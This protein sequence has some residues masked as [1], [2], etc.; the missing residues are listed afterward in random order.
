MLWLI[1]RF[2]ESF[3]RSIFTMNLGCR[4]PSGTSRSTTQR[5]TRR[6]HASAWRHQAWSWG[7]H[8]LQCSCGEGCYVRLV[9]SLCLLFGYR[10][11]IRSYIDL[12]S[13]VS[14]SSACAPYFHHSWRGLLFHRQIGHW[15]S[16]VAHEHALVVLLSSCWELE[17]S[18]SFWVIWRLLRLAEQ[19]CRSLYASA[20][21]WHSRI[22]LWHVFSRVISTQYGQTWFTNVQ[23]CNLLHGTC[24]SRWPITS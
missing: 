18:L 19:W 16:A 15:A 10:S 23:R 24:H 1:S 2:S 11:W 21:D 22:R 6:W 9:D 12:P 14:G 7:L 20:L 5:P 17:Q 8:L 3:G 4:W 13:T